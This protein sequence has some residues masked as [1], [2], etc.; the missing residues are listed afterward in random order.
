MEKTHISYILLGFM[1]Q[2]KKVIL[3]K[4]EKLFLLRESK[5]G[6]SLSS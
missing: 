2:A 6:E 4:K 1:P 5:T 3:E